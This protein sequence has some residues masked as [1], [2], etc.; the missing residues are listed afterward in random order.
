M[1]ENVALKQELDGFDV[2]AAERVCRRN[3]RPEQWKHMDV[4]HDLFQKK[5]YQ[6]QQRH[7]ISEFDYF[8]PPKPKE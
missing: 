2:K 7:H 1:Q 6:L 5:R 8:D 3:T 4:F